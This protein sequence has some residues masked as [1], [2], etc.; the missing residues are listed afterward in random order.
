MEWKYEDITMLNHIE[1][2]NFY[3]YRFI[4]NANKKS[5]SPV[6]VGKNRPIN[7]HGPINGQDPF[8][9]KESLESD[10][11]NQKEDIHSDSE[12]EKDID[13]KDIDSDQNR[14]RK[15]GIR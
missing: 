7:G 1:L 2:Y 15:G 9:F 4:T 13:Q 11:F 6:F 3:S 14:I 10:S 12:S 8:D 5:I